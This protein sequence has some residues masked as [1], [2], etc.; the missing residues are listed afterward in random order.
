MTAKR[1]NRFS[2]KKQRAETEKQRNDPQALSC[3]FRPRDSSC[4]N[5]TH[6]GNQASFPTI[7]AQWR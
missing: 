3:R 6:S 4:L 2:Q 7:K 5:V 1:G